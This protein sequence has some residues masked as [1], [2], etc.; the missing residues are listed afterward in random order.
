MKKS[1]EMTD[2]GSLQYFL[3]LEVDQRSDGVFLSQKKYAEG[4]LIWFNMTQCKKTLTPM[5]TNE[6]LQLNDG[7]GAADRQLY[8]SLIG[9]L[10]YL[11]NTRPDI[12]FS[13]GMVSRFVNNPTKHHYSVAKRILRYISGTVDHGMWYETTSIFNLIGFSDSDWAGALE[14]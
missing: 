2:L 11:V 3:G 1:F 9:G 12:A 7:S 10:I 5:N 4:V 14:D 8:R 13:V 6:K